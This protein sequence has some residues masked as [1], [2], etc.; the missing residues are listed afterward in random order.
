MTATGKCSAGG[1]CFQTGV[2]VVSFSGAINFQA[3]Q[4]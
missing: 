4:T 1:F 2:V 3:T